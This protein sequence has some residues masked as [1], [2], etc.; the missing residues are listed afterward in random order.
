MISGIPRFFVSWSYAPQEEL[1]SRVEAEVDACEG[2]LKS[3]Y[4]DDMAY[5]GHPPPVGVP[6]TLPAPPPADG[7]LAPAPAKPPPKG[8]PGKPPR[9]FNA[10]SVLEKRQDCR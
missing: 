1:L 4:Y 5:W 2:E 10:P 7:T 6:L 8:P 3:L 9:G